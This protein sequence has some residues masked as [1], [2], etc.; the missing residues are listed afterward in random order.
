MRIDII[1]EF[2]VRVVPTEAGVSTAAR[3]LGERTQ[4]PAAL[5]EIVQGRFVEQAFFDALVDGERRLW[6]NF[7]E[8]GRN[9]P[10]L[11]VLESIGFERCSDGA[12]M[13]LDLTRHDL[14]CDFIAVSGDRGREAAGLAVTSA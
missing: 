5:K 12:G 1:A 10:A 4:N 3:T 9:T 2:F 6:V 8:T 7:H 11:Q 13:A 14:S